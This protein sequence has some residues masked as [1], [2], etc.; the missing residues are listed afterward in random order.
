[1]TKTRTLCVRNI[2]KGR[3]EMSL[4]EITGDYI[5]LIDAIEAGEI[6]EEAIAD[7]LE[8]VNGAWDE[9]A[10][11]VLSAVKNYRAECEAIRNE[12]KALAERRKRK[13]KVIE[14]LEGYFTDSLYRVGRTNY[15]SARHNVRFTT[16]S[17]VVV[18][19]IDALIKYAKKNAPD[20]IV[21][22]VEVSANKDVLKKLLKAGDVPGVELEIR[23]N[24]QIK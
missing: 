1:M 4:Y 3:K 8:A 5:R 15:E 18:K 17:A 16:S 19:D 24:F 11:A 12:E 6:P 10:D 2:T 21:K 20:A 22:K 23:S 13:E 7:T 14:R 9:R